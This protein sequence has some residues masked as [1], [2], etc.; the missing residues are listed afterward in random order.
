MAVINRVLDVQPV[1]SLA[2]YLAS[3]GGE[4]LVAARK[5]EPEAL[6]STIED[7]GLR[8]RGGAGFPTATKWRSVLANA[9]S[10]QPTPVV[11]NGAEGEPSTF[12]DRAILRTNPYRVLE[13]ALIACVVVDASELVVCVKRSFAA[14]RARLHGAVEELRAEGWLD[15]IGVRFVDGP[16]AYLFGEETALLEVAHQGC[17]PWVEDFAEA[18]DAIKV[19]LVSVP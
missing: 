7:S 18:L 3:G 8:G 9:S 2:D 19:L 11:I 12:K 16:D 13:G 17:P 4:A 1:L 10:S 15:G 6:V 14:E 5:V